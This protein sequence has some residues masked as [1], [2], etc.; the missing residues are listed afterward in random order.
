MRISG[1]PAV[2]LEKRIEMPKLRQVHGIQVVGSAPYCEDWDAMRSRG[3]LW[4]KWFYCGMRANW[5]VEEM[6][7]KL[8]EDREAEKQEL[9][10]RFGIND[11]YSYQG[12]LCINGKGLNRGGKARVGFV[13]VALFIGVWWVRRRRREGSMFGVE[14]KPWMKKV[15]LVCCNES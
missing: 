3:V 4:G 8:G 2:D 14:N 10:D 1:I 12:R 15:R 6:E 11:C 9:E 7:H 5:T 13:M